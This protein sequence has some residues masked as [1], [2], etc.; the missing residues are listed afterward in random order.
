MMTLEAA[1]V[2]AVMETS[3]RKGESWPGKTGQALKW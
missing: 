2:F 1:Q 3:Y